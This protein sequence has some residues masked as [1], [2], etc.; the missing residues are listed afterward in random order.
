MSPRRPFMR[1]ITI[2]FAGSPGPEIR[3]R[4]APD[5]AEDNVARKSCG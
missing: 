4:N 3:R 5:P 1:F 2:R